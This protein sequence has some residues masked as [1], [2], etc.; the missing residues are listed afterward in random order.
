MSKHLLALSIG[1]VQEFIAAARRTRDLWFG[2]CLLSELSKATALAVARHP[3]VGTSGLIFPAP[4]TITALEPAAELGADSNLTVANIILAELPD[5][6]PPRELVKEAREAAHKRWLTFAQET[7][8]A[9]KSFIRGE[10]WN[11]QLD[12][13]IEFYAA[14][15]PLNGNYGAARQRVMRLLAG[16]KACRDFGQ[17]KNNVGTRLP[18]SSLDG[19]RETVL[20]DNINEVRRRLRL[21]QGEQLCAIGLT[22]RLAGGM[23]LYP[24]VSRIAADPWLRGLATAAEKNAKV[25]AAF[26]Q[27][28]ALC[29]QFCNDGN[30][31]P[32]NEDRFPRFNGFP[33]EGT[34]VLQNRFNEWMQETG[35]TKEAL[36][37]LKVVLDD[38]RKL[39]FGDPDPYLAVLVADGDRMGAILSATQEAQEHREFSK[40]LAAFATKA[41]NIVKNHYGVCVFAGGDDVLA[42]VPVDKSLQCA[43]KLR[44]E[45]ANVKVPNGQAPKL[46]V[47]IAIGHCME[48]LED[49]REY[50]QQ[51]EK[52]AKT[53]TPD[54]DRQGQF[55]ERN[56]LAVMVH[57]R[58]GVDFGVREQW[59]PDGKSLDMRLA[60]WAGLFSA[61]K[62]PNKLPYDLRALA[63]GL[64]AWPDPSDA[65]KKQSAPTEAVQAEARLLL[66][67]K[68]V[69]EKERKELEGVLTT[70]NTAADLV[71]LAEEMLVAQWIAVAQRQAGNSGKKE[72]EA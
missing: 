3:G 66:K 48:P 8:K 31:H 34:C 56:G 23:Q 1:P 12:D 51:A 58:G 35:L 17:P 53:R 67:R 62:L 22:K 44:D 15:V 46:S 11:E 18:K 9:A 71:R 32:L 2:S 45:F 50:G 24:S 13:A 49:L 60:E 19:R 72:G 36:Q 14:W 59:Q 26:K 43:R 69:K 61:C 47:G 38:L 57:P 33:F 25:A 10:L 64:Q 68:Q 39:D 27:L 63:Q 37:P 28:Q 54:T 42:F 29:R 65:H 52:A 20:H 40:G 70:C 6:V 21:A 5:G 16:R 55:A 4:D 30:L 7:Y 41:G